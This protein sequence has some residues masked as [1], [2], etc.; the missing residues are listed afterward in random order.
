MDSFLKGYLKVL[1]GLAALAVIIWV[2]NI[3][4]R[5]GELSDLLADDEE[6]RAY[7]YTFVV[8]AVNGSVATISSPRSAEVSA[9]LALKALYPELA[10]QSIQSPAME[11]AQKE[12]AYLQSKA[13]NII[14][15]QAD[16][17]R[18]AWQLD[19]RW[20]ENHGIRP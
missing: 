18:I 13:A 9:T 15:Q 16:I 3:D 12:L 20:L 17:D 10:N 19:E 6:L 5:A 11:H 2:A 7:P 14:K 8:V 4:F 1:G